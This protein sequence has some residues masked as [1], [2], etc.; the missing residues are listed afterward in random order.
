MRETKYIIKIFMMN[1]NFELKKM[2]EYKVNYMLDLLSNI[3]F[4]CS[5]L[6]F[7]ECLYS[8]AYEIPMWN[9]SEMFVFLAF[10][11]LFFGI[12][13]GLFSN[14]ARFSLFI[15]SGKLDAYLVRPVN[16][17]IKMLFSNL[18]IFELIKG[19]SMF[20]MLIHFSSLELS[21][22]NLFIGILV[23]I[24]GVII[25][26]LIQ[27]CISFIS[28]KFGRVDAIIEIIDSLM[29]FNK[30]PLNIFPT[31]I[32]F[33]FKYF[34]PFALFST[35]PALVSI[36]DTGFEGLMTFLFMAIIICIIWIMITSQLWKRAGKNYESYNS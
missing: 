7:W 3:L 32:F 11:E 24:M 21:I 29:N 33:L 12:K 19:A 20:F 31:C 14:A 13:G 17:V 36:S 9:R 27:V 1:M 35:I 16:A 30:Y 34:L 5:N 2:K 4:V 18:N 22:L 10:V 23:C 8:N 28:F 25:L 15:V 6:L 26:S